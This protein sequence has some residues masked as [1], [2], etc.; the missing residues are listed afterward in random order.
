[1]EEKFGEWKTAFVDVIFPFSI[2]QAKPSLK[3]GTGEVTTS[4][5]CGLGR[6]D[7]KML[8]KVIINTFCPLV[9]LYPALSKLS[10]RKGGKV[11]AISWCV[12]IGFLFY[13]YLLLCFLDYVPVNDNPW[14]MGSVISGTNNGTAMS[15][16]ARYYQSSRYG[17]FWE[18]KQRVTEANGGLVEYNYA[19]DAQAGETLKVAVSTVPGDRMTRNYRIEAIGWFLYF[20]MATLLTFLRGEV[21]SCTGCKTGSIMEDFCICCFYS[22]AI[23]QM[24]DHIL[25]GDDDKSTEAEEGEANVG[26]VRI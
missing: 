24:E 3:P 21:R 17:Y 5:N 15:T 7:I 8:G 1:M 10:K 23:V 12:M 25:W 14:I 18:Y 19:Y 26:S 20:F 4:C 2:Y 16:D 6:I 13:S 22:P 11:K 9:S